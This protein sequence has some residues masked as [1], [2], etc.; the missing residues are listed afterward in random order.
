MKKTL[1]GVALLILLGLSFLVPAVLLAEGDDVPRITI[2][3]LKKMMD[4]KVPVVVLDAQPKRIYDKG[5]IKGAIS[6]PWT[7]KLS[8]EQVAALPKGRPIVV[9]CDCGPG[10]ADSVSVAERLIERGFN[11]VKVLADP[12]IRGWKDAGFPIE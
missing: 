3:E 12:S 1:P 9:Y 2:Q 5:H 10:E 7:P 8:E 11:D 4:N 6:F